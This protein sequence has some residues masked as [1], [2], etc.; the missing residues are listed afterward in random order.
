[1]Q[2][3]TAG[4]C[5]QHGRSSQT[6]WPVSHLQALGFIKTTARMN[7]NGVD[8]NA[9]KSTKHCRCQDAIC[10]HELAR[11]YHCARGMGVSHEEKARAD[12][13]KIKGKASSRQHQPQRGKS[14]RQGG[15]IRGM[16]LV[17][18]DQGVFVVI[19]L[20]LLTSL[21]C[22]P[23]ARVLASVASHGSVGPI[24]PW[25]RKGWDAMSAHRVIIHKGGGVCAWCRGS[26]SKC[27]GSDLRT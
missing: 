1:M 26:G 5:S 9:S 15:V 21:R 24:A 7:R 3:C 12:N 11:S 20:T 6:V 17:N 4:Y 13:E 19:F 8:I 16:S 10:G 18:T 14:Q 23:A 2:W 22:M 25:R 27:D